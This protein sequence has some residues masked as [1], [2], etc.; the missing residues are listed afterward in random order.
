MTFANAR[1]VAG[2]GV[3][4]VAGSPGR[5]PVARST[6][7]P[8]TVVPP[9]SMPNPMTS[10]LAGTTDE[11]PGPPAYALCRWSWRTKTLREMSVGRAIVDGCTDP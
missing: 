10:T 1:G 11:H 8:L 2:E 6:G 3:S 7:E 4:T 5:R 9:K